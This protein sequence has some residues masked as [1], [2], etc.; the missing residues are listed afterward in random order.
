MTTK[1]WIVEE[2][3]YRNWIWTHP[4]SADDVVAD[5]KAG[6]VPVGF[7]GLRQGVGYQGTCEEFYPRDDVWDRAEA[8]VKDIDLDV[9]SENHPHVVAAVAMLEVEGSSDAIMVRNGITVTAHVHMH[10]DTSLTAYGVT[11]GPWWVEEWTLSNVLENEHAMPYTDALKAIADGQVLV[12]GV[13][14]T[15]PEVKVTD[16]STVTVQGV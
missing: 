6:L 4:G 14:T 3:G 1:T 12:S 13:V 15:D 16:V 9:T 2:Y 7:M 8:M 11:Y 10:E 5:W